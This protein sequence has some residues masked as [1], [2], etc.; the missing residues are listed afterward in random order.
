[1]ITKYGMSEK[2]GPMCFGS[3][4]DEVFLG[5]DLA[6]TRNYSENVACM[7]DEEMKRIIDECYNKCEELLST[8]MELLHEVSKVLLEKEKIEG[9]E[10][11]K[12]FNSVM[13]IEEP[14]KE[15]AELTVEKEEQVSEE[16]NENV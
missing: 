2:L 1:M 10:F 3:E 5:K 8:H 12:I 16:Q 9:D 15:E 13:G 11:L 6:Q 7:I 4:Q 14:E